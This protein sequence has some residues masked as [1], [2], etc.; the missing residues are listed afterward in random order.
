MKQDYNTLAVRQSQSK[1]KGNKFKVN[2]S[3]RYVS[4]DAIGAVA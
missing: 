2:I 1:S 4:V 3:K